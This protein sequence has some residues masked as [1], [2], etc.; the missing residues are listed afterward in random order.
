[1]AT[2]A[3]TKI[4]Y[5]EKTGEVLSE[6][7]FQYTEDDKVIGF[8]EN[9]QFTKTFMNMIPN[10]TQ[11]NF[12]GYFSVLCHKIQRHTNVVIRKEDSVTLP[13]SKQDIVDLFE[14][15]PRTMERFLSEANK[16][17]A[18]AKAEINGQVCYVLNPTY[19]Y[20]GGG[21]SSFL[22]ILFQHDPNFLIFLT[23]NQ[24]NKYNSL[25]G[26]DYYAHLEKNFPSIYARIKK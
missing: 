12:L 25:T 13:M 16:I 7:E 6:R 3:I 19:A 4:K 24:I 21:I 5:D 18:I 20:N 15:T 22:F 1:M 17:G 11:M 2:T 10:F 26:D 14:V 8:K 9:S 23:N